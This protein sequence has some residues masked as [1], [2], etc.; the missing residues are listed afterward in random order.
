ME[1]QNGTLCSLGEALGFPWLSKEILWKFYFRKTIDEG[2]L[3]GP[4]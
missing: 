4:F 3:L 2:T 1:V